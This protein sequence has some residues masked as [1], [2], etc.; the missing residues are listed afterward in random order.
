M[1]RSERDAFVKDIIITRGHHKDTKKGDVKETLVNLTF[2]YFL[3][4]TMIHFF[5]FFL[6]NVKLLFVRML[7]LLFDSFSAFDRILC[8]VL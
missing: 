4:T 8:T 2:R 5:V 7:F 3:T 6:G 1:F